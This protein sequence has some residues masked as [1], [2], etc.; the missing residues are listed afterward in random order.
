MLCSRSDAAAE[1]ARLHREAEARCRSS[2]RYG[3]REHGD[4]GQSQTGES[5]RAADEFWIT[6]LVT[7]IIE[8]GDGGSEDY[9]PTQGEAH[10][11]GE[12]YNAAEDG[13]PDTEV[14]IEVG[15]RR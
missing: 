7:T 4:R 13:G 2:G 6:D 1:Q 11:Y 5:P 8:S 15:G 9:S 12:Y 14:E 10:V 3:L